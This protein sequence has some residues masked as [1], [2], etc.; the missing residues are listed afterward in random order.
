MSTQ[1]IMVM[2]AVLAMVVA[3]GGESYARGG[4][5][6]ARSG[7]GS[8]Q[9]NRTQAHSQTRTAVQSAPQTQVRPENSQRRDGTFL[10]TG[11]TAN[12]STTRPSK[13]RGVM[14][15]S[16]LEATTTAVQ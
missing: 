4:G 13:G 7:G 6:G 1:R 12:G 11:T 2:T 3:F 9:Q 10:E 15:D 8:M 5:G 14:D 16:A